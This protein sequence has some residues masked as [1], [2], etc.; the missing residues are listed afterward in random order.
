MATARLVHRVLGVGIPEGLSPREILSRKIFNFDLIIGTL[1]TLG[2]GI[3]VVAFPENPFNIKLVNCLI[4]GVI[5]LLCLFFTYRGYYAQ[6]VIASLIFIYLTLTILV[7]FGSSPLDPLFL[8]PVGLNGLIYLSDRTR[9]SRTIFLLFAMT[10]IGLFS[11]LAYQAEIDAVNTKDFFNTALVSLPTLGFV[12]MY[13]ILALILLF[14]SSIQQN[15]RNKTQLQSVLNS[16]Y[17]YQV[18]SLDKNYQ[19]VT[20]NENF[21]QGIKQEFDIELVPGINLKKILTELE[22]P[23]LP[24]VEEAI[25]GKAHT[26]IWNFIKKNGNQAHFELNFYPLLTPEGNQE[27]CSIF[28]ADI[29]H[30]K[31]AEDHAWLREKIVLGIVQNYPSIYYCFDEEL[32]F[33]ESVGSGLKAL[34]LTDNQLVGH[35]IREVYRDHP[36]TINY[37]EKALKGEFVSYS[38]MVQVGEH[39]I[40]YEV[41]AFFDEK[42]QSGIGLAFDVTE[43]MQAEQE[44]E[45][46]NKELLKANHELD[47]FVYK[48]SHDLR[49]PLTSLLGLVNLARACDEEAEL[50][51]TLDLQERSVTKLDN[52]VKL[53]GEFTRNARSPVTHELVDL[54]ELLDECLTHYGPAAREQHI[55]LSGEAKAENCHADLSRLRIILNNLM[56]NAIKYYDPNKDK[57]TLQLELARENGTITLLVRDNGRGI[58]SEHV[59]KAFDMFYRAHSNSVGSGLGLYI[60]KETVEKMKGQVELTSEEGAFTQFL[61]QI[62]NGSA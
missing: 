62:P 59:P 23:L 18:I 20:A 4:P 21:S 60:V 31:I 57:R 42:T 53:I 27:G 22:S 25:G 24:W 40:Y 29:T 30:E 50:T 5:F 12:L 26:K 7:F 54:Q 13:K 32:I 61:V 45:R 33:T 37:H 56:S 28:A 15:Q 11:F 3:W 47:N 1:I 19:L 51:Q 10:G 2:F 44:L 35:S 39:K 9:F 43:K 48:F 36:D 52:Y 38:T 49:G 16:N 6:V 34:G 58:P 55:E 14:Q 41:K 17:R 8:I 46:Q